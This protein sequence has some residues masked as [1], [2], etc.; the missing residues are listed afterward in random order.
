MTRMAT[1]GQI[2]VVDDNPEAL[3]LLV[4]ILTDTGYDV[5]AAP[6]G[7]LALWSALLHPPDLIALDVRM[8]G[9]DGFETCRALKRQECTAGVPVIFIS[10]A[11]DVNDRLAGFDAGGVDFIVK[12]YAAAEVLARIGT[13]MRM[14]LAAKQLLA[15]RA[16][17]QVSLETASAT[18]PATAR[19]AE[20]LVVE[21]TPESLQLLSAVLA[22][23]GYVV[24]EAANG[25]LALWTA[26]KRPPDLILL[27]I[28][29]PGM[30]GFDVCRCLKADPA[31]AGIPVIF[32]SA[33]SDIEDKAE[34]FSVGA[35]DFITKPF[36]EQEV[37][38][39]VKSHLRLATSQPSQDAVSASGR[40]GQSAADLIPHRNLEDIFAGSANAVALLDAEGK[41]TYAN[42][43]FTQL[44]GRVVAES[45]TLAF[46]T[47]VRTTA[48]QDPWPEFLR[49]GHW[50]GEIGLQQASGGSPLPCHLALSSI[51]AADGS[52]H[53][54]VAVLHDLS[55][56]TAGENTL[57]Y[58]AHHE[59]RE[60]PSA[61]ETQ[62]GALPL[63][64]LLHGAL[65]RNEIQLLYQPLLNPRAGKVTAARVIP[66]WQAPGM[67]ALLPAA[68]MPLAE[69]TGESLAIGAWVLNMACRQLNSWAPRLPAD[70]RLAIELTSLQFWQDALARTVLEALQAANLPG[71]RLALEV[72]AATLDEDLDQGIAI[73]RRIGALGVTLICDHAAARQAG[74]VTASLGEA[75]HPDRVA[76]L[77]ATRFAAEFLQRHG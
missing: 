9:L 12:P 44:V 60:Q 66:Q 75:Q 70:F 23:A 73:L 34:G 2:L 5:R 52:L 51:T 15:R 39:R 38:A 53:R 20:I 76:P 54:A 16:A 11:S 43:N 26:S 42:P 71:G 19:S 68:Y 63:D 47:L 56:K 18:T 57:D 32:I 46:S 35:V 27:D 69:A 48:G 58:L 22:D 21:D 3:H 28:R 41:L 67:K 55:G 33:M 8:P 31:T 29:M 24:R 74:L 50:H 14:A 30:N 72:S 64:T 6:S 59:L 37:I 36:A 61:F 49:Q 1:P 4:D 40:D 25:E 10:G 45:R 13:H 65:Q 17:A 7:E 77:P 62:S